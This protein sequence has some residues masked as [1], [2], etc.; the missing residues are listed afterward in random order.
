MTPRTPVAAAA[1]IF[2]SS[3]ALH[4]FQSAAAV[5]VARGFQAF[6]DGRLE[7]LGANGRACSDCHTPTDHF[8]LSPADVEQRYGILA[9]R[10]AHDPDAD[11]PLFRPIDA[12]DFRVNGD[13]AADF[14]TLR[15]HALIRVTLPLPSN[16]S[17]IDP[18]T[19][20]KSVV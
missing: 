19:D 3:I 6:R 12:D 13:R 11:D 1:G 16:M 2:V 20:R 14:S 5:D 7:G 10:R 17:L 15:Q 4:A 9:L 8:Q 18:A